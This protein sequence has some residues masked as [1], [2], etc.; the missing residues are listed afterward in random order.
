MRNCG[1]S[2]MSEDPRN[3]SPDDPRNRI[4]GVEAKAH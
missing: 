1:S 3:G 4:L 2:G